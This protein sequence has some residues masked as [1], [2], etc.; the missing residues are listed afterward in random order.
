M[1]TNHDFRYCHHEV[2][3]HHFS[4]EPSQCHRI[5]A[6]AAVVQSNMYFFLCVHKKSLVSDVAYQS[7][8]DTFVLVN[9]QNRDIISKEDVPSCSPSSCSRCCSTQI[10][11]DDVRNTRI[12]GFVLRVV[13]EPPCFSW[14]QICGLLFSLVPGGHWCRHPSPTRRVSSGMLAAA[15]TC[16]PTTR[17][18]PFHPRVRAQAKAVG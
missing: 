7:H 8:F 1:A 18:S 10:L 17:M 11:G 5:P 4:G 3:G 2:S 14:R 16:A 6:I 12:H 15:D 9:M 13:L